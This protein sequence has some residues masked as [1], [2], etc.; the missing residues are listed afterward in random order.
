MKKIRLT[1]QTEIEVYRISDTDKSLTI[2]LL[3]ADANKTEK[4][5]CNSSNLDIIQYYVGADIIKGYAGFTKLQ[6]YEK[7]MD[8][9]LSIDYSVPDASTESGFAEEKGNILTLTLIRPSKITAIAAKTEQNTADIDYIEME[10][11]V[12]V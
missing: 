4:V 11:G 9:T 12:N 3:N 5:F 6:K 10:M 2:S 1:D 8:Q 7:L